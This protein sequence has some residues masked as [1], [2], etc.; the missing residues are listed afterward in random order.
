MKLCVYIYDRV[1]WRFQVCLLLIMVNIL[2]KNEK[3]QLKHITKLWWNLVTE[4]NMFRLINTCMECIHICGCMV[5][6]FGVLKLMSNV[7]MNVRIRLITYR[8]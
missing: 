3:L 6:L 2:C 8:Q 1:D 4:I 7:Y 5:S